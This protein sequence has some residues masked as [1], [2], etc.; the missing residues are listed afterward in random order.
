MIAAKSARWP[1]FAA[2]AGPAARWRAGPATV[3]AVAVARGALVLAPLLG[4]LLS[5]SGET[6]E[7]WGHLAAT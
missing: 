7:I 5:R 3:S 2:T 1:S 6:G 4:L